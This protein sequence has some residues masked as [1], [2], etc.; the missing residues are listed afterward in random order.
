[1]VRKST[2]AKEKRNRGKRKGK[3]G[4]GRRGTENP[5]QREQENKKDQNA[6]N[7]RERMIEKER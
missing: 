7:D 6:K 3:T 1:M 4:R 2:A 5:V